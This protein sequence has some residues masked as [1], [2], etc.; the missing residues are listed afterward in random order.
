MAYVRMDGDRLL[1]KRPA[2][3][4]SLD[5]AKGYLAAVRAELDAAFLPSPGQSLRIDL[6]DESRGGVFSRSGVAIV[7][8][9]HEVVDFIRSNEVN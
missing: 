2:T 7:G 4:L 1:I 8:L 6:E 3:N 9:L 5:A